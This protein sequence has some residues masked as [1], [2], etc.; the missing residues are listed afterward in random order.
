[1]NKKTM[2]LGLICL[3]LSGCVFQTDFL[4]VEKYADKVIQKYHLDASSECQ[5]V[6]SNIVFVVKETS[7]QVSLECSNIDNMGC[8][9]AGPGEIVVSL[10]N[11]LKAQVREQVGNYIE[12]CEE[13]E[14]K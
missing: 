14:T 7:E 5:D 13:K 3:S 2:I 9:L 8:F 12:S 11:D 1:M 6:N 10:E 4:T